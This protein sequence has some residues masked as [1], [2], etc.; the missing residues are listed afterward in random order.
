MERR[1]D[2]SVGQIR[3]RPADK[4]SFILILAVLRWEALTSSNLNIPILTNLKTEV[5]FRIETMGIEEGSHMERGGGG[6]GEE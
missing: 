3:V 6:E 4:K 1:E 5:I 2:T